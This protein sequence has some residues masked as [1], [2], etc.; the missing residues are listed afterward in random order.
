MNSDKLVD[1]VT[2]TV[3]EMLKDENDGIRVGVSAR[4]VHLSQADWRPCLAR[5]M[6]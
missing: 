1:I 4:H 6:N 5:V 3:M 2:K